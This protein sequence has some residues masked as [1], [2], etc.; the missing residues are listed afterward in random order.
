M[1]GEVTCSIRIWQS[2]RVRVGGRYR[3]GP[4]YVEVTRLIEI[5]LSD[6]TAEVARRS[7]FADLDDLMS[8]AGPRRG[9]AVVQG[10]VE[11]LRQNPTPPP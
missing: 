11:E 9:G 8:I 1:R 10:G 5:D 3:L 6:V 2:P 4:G 7:G